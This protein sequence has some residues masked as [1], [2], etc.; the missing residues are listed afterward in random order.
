MNGILEA[1]RTTLLLIQHFHLQPSREEEIQRR[2]E[3]I[4]WTSYSCKGIKN[5]VYISARPWEVMSAAKSVF[6]QHRTGHCA[7]I[8]HRARFVL[9]G[10]ENLQEGK[11]PVQSQQFSSMS[12]LSSSLRMS[13]LLLIGKNS[14]SP[15]LLREYHSLFTF[16]QGTI[17]VFIA[18]DSVLDVDSID[19]LSFIVFIEGNSFF[20]SSLREY[21]L[22]LPPRLLL[23]YRSYTTSHTNVA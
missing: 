20:H 4:I 15:L 1:F 12:P 18:T 9:I 2:L 22:K 10:V 23:L 11:H 5:F 3:E 17:K 14:T 13:S 16:D 6:V 7:L 21:S 8:P 19:R